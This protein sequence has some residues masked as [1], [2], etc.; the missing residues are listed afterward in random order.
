MQRTKI[1]ICLLASVLMS[2]AL[3]KVAAQASTSFVQSDAIRIAY[4]VVGEGDPIVLIPGF[5]QSRVA[6]KAAGFVDAFVARG[7]Q[8]ILLD[9][10]GHGE[11][12]KPHEPSAYRLELL[13]TDLT[14]VLDE[15]EIDQVD[16]LGYSRGGATAIATAIYRP[17]R[18]RS[19]IVGGAHPYAEDMGPFR[20][21]VAAGIDGWISVIESNV[22]PL[23]TDARAMFL[24]ND[25]TALRAAVAIDRPNL[26]RELVA[27]GVPALFYAGS[28]DPRAEAARRFADTTTATYV[29]LDGLNHFQAFFATT[30]VVEA[31]E[32]LLTLNPN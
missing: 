31:A 20:D 2:L 16:L 18:V 12:D 30:L 3:P 27:S 5:S 7:R 32:Q 29:E 11:S 17:A 15:L 22:G 28:E 26:A 13:A 10:R 8:V 6:W 4:E 21:A 14:A 24:A 9:P 23:P 19:I 25:A 1:A